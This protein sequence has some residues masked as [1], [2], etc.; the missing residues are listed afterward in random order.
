MPKRKRTRAKRAILKTEML[1]NLAWLEPA[2]DALLVTFPPI[3]ERLCPE[4]WEKAA[5]SL[6][7]LLHEAAPPAFRQ[8]QIPMCLFHV[9]PE[10]YARISLAAVWPA[11]RAIIISRTANDAPAIAK[12]LQKER[13]LLTLCNETHGASASTYWDTCDIEGLPHLGHSVFTKFAETLI[14]NIA[15]FTTH[16]PELDAFQVRGD[17]SWFHQRT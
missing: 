16:A 8:Q 2:P 5:R 7:V 10:G 3:N 1:V 17:I 13:L 12:D 4:K 9:N 6:Y 11:R 14:T 15:Y